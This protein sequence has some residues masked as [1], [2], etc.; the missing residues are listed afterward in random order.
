MSGDRRLNGFGTFAGGGSLGPGGAIGLG[1]AVG[2]GRGKVAGPA[3]LG[4]SIPSNTNKPNHFDFL[5][6]ISPHRPIISSPT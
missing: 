4:T 1:G 5:V 3:A 2:T 6:L